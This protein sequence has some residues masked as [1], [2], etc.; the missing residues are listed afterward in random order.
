MPRTNVKPKKKNT[1]TK[2][3]ASKKAKQV[4]NSTDWGDLKKVIKQRD[5]VCT[6]S[7]YAIDH[8][9]HIIPMRLA[10]YLKFIPD[11]L[12][13]LSISS[14]STKTE[15]DNISFTIET[16]FNIVFPFHCEQ[17]KLSEYKSKKLKEK[18]LKMVEMNGIKKD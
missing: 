11:N 16:W 15:L 13:G 1:R 8:I 18:L 2:D 14:H 4:Y 5:K 17:L 7:G 6:Y 3:L 12:Q 10:P 9:D